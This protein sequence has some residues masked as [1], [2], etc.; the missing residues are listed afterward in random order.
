MPPTTNYTNPP[1]TDEYDDDDE[2]KIYGDPETYA[3][4]K[5]FIHIGLVVAL[6]FT[7]LTYKLFEPPLTPPDFTNY[8]YLHTLNASALDLDAPN[9][10][11]IMVGDLHG[12]MHSFDNLM[13]KLHYNPEDDLIVHMGDIVAKGPHSNELLS[14]FAASNITGVRGNNDQKVIEWYGWISWV[15]SHSSGA[16]WLKAIEKENISTKEAKKM[17]LYENSKYPFAED[18][19]WN[20]DHYHVARKMSP[21]DYTYLTSLPILIHLPSLHTFMVHGG[22]LPADF[23]HHLHS[24]RQPLAKVPKSLPHNPTYADIERAR[25]VQE[26]SLLKGVEANKD[27]YVL[28]NIRDLHDLRPSRRG[29]KGHDDVVPWS[30]A[31]NSVIDRCHGFD[32]EG[33][34]GGGSDEDQGK[35]KKKRKKQK[36]QPKNRFDLVSSDHQTR[37]EEDVEEFDDWNDSTARTNLPCHPI[38]V[39]YSHAS[40][41]G[42]DLKSW[43]KGLD[44][45][46]VNGNGLTAMILGPGRHRFPVKGHKHGSEGGND[47]DD[48]KDS[49]RDIEIPF[50]ENLHARLFT[51]ACPTP[52]KQD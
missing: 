12:M 15:E 52:P 22:L 34:N 10:R 36:K 42:L 5:L 29:P 11:I 18:W 24:K 2:H 16:R 27:P 14:R 1:H 48:G 50:G 6:F 28:M 35:D 43:S 45:G 13:S 32:D 39:V 51:V 44:T 3:L 47:D 49:A 33:G 20:G 7:W 46:C 40:S 9:R 21:E 37:L 41:R 38:T 17:G 31:W 8:T 19:E 26:L 25:T 23:L 30:E 4:R